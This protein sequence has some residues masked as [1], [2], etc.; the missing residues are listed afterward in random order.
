MSIHKFVRY[1]D[2]RVVTSTIEP[3]SALRCTCEAHPVR[4]NEIHHVNAPTELVC[5][6][7]HETLLTHA[8]KLEPR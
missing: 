1:A 7:C 3:G 4:I 5:G 6:N 2:D 8:A